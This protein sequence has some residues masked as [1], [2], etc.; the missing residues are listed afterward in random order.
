M[1]NIPAQNKE[2]YVEDEDNNDEIDDTGSETSD[3]PEGE[4]S[5][6]AIL[7]HHVEPDDSLLYKIQWK[8]Y[9]DPTWEP[10]ENLEHSMELVAFYWK[11]IA[12]ARN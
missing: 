12:L 3:I 1:E 2:M 10:E 5:V 11:N 8:G 4:Y 9:E 6:E 7:E